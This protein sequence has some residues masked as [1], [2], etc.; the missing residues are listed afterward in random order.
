MQQFN[1][2][3]NPGNTSQTGR[4]SIFLAVMPE[5]TNESFYLHAKHLKADYFL[6]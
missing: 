2:D 4:F 3:M 5:E 6:I 1:L